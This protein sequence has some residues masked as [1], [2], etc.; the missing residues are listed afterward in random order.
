[1]AT[2]QELIRD[3]ARRIE[4]ALAKDNFTPKRK[5]SN[6]V[7]TT[8]FTYQELIR[9]K[10]SINNLEF[11]AT[12][13][14]VDQKTKDEIIDG[15]LTQLHDKISQYPLYDSLNERVSVESASNDHFSDL[16]DTIE[17]ILRDNK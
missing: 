14:P 12:K 8:S 7:F 9:I 13:N 11:T 4:Q 6:F 16:G 15:V 5:I 3:Y 17:Q 1:M 2:K 10:K